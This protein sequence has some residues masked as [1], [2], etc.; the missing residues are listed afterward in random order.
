M[1]GIAGFCDFSK[2]SNAAI[3]QAMTDVIAYRGPDDQGQ[4]MQEF[5]DAVVGLGHRRL[6]ILD[7]S[8]LGHQPYHFNDISLIFN[9]EIYNFQEIREKLIKRGYTFKSNSDT[10][11]IIKSYEANG[12]SCVDDFIGMF[13]FA[14]LDHKKEKIFLVRDRAGV[15]PMYYYWK[16]DILLFGSELK[17]FHENPLFEKK[18]DPDSIALFFQY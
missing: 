1:C 5:P 14:L 11:V 16:N 6:S 4:F 10:E 3:L 12:I 17:S 2:K 9:G 8:P 18:V 15:K 13:S 7:L